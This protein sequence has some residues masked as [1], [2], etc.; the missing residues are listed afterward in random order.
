MPQCISKQRHLAGDGQN[1]QVTMCL[2]LNHLIDASGAGKT[3][4]EYIE[5]EGISQNVIE[6]TS[7]ESSQYGIPQNIYEIKVLMPGRPER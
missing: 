6:N 3:E 1:V 5:N 7:A 4:G 2:E